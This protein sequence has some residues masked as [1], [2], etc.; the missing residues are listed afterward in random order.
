MV[1]GRWK[2][3]LIEKGIPNKEG[4]RLEKF[5]TN[6][7]EISKW[8]AE[9]LPSDELSIQNGILTKNASRWPLCVDP[10]LQAVVWIKEKEKKNNLEI[11]S[12]NQADY[13]KRLEMAISFGKPVLFEAIDEEIDPMI[14]PILEKNIVVQAG[15]RMIKLGD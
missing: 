4:F 3:D 10:Q 14:D 1:Y 9:G 15:V 6:D 13:I 11:L 7:V 8:S 2:E 12:F 5:L